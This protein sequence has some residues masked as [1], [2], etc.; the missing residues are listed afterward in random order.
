[1]LSDNAINKD[2][3]MI[4]QFFGGNLEALIALIENWPGYEKLTEKIRK[5]AKDLTN[6]LKRTGAVDEKSFCVLN[7]G[8]LWV[9]NVLFKYDEQRKPVD[10]N[11]VDFQMSVWNTPA[12]DL[13]Y[14]FYTSLELDVL[15]NKLDILLKEYHR[16]L[17]STL[18]EL[19]Y[20]DIPTYQDIYN[21]FQKRQLYGFFAN[22]GILPIVCQDKE[23]SQDSSLENFNDADF[24]KQ[25]MQQI[26][27]SKRLEATYRY[28][29]Q[30]FDQMGI[31]D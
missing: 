19:N 8:D 31:F 2:Q 14:F 30:K 9:N 5:Y 10:I 22:Y 13:N 23:L 16:S 3:G 25:K 4:I 17:S 27:A 11:F 28:T 18:K 20:I 7:H 26:F 24:A 15:K 1:M 21:D 12:I 6:N 29:L